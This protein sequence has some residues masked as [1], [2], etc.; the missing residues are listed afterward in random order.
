M[1]CFK[2]TWFKN[3]KVLP[4]SNRYTADYDYNTGVA[5][6]KIDGA[7]S[8]DLGNYIVLAENP[9]GSD[10]TNC[11]VSVTFV[12][13]VDNTPLVNPDAFRYLENAAPEKRRDE[14]EPMFPPKV[15]VPLA[16]VKVNEGAPVQLACKIEGLPKP[17]VFIFKIKT[18]VFL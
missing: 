11:T 17:T 6:L 14:K 8:N 7:Q 12:P 1:N 15:I 2:L 10:K 4:A 5:T 9:A 3:G 13:N 16:N 18:Q